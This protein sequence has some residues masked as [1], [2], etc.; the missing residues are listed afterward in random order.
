MAGKSWSGEDKPLPP[1]SMAEAWISAGTCRPI[2]PCSKFRRPFSGETHSHLGIRVSSFSQRPPISSRIRAASS[3]V[4]EKAKGVNVEDLIQFLYEDLPHLFD[5][6]GI[7]RSRY[8]ERVKFRDPI[9]SHDTVDGYLFNITL[10]KLI[11]RPNFQLHYV[12]QVT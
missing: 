6:Q 2:V 10:L 8:D 3:D 1:Q 9:T 4:A 12:K 7:D 5:D 11:F